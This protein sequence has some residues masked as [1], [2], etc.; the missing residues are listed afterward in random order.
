MN[1]IVADAITRHMFP[2]NVTPPK[3]LESWLVSMVDKVVAAYEFIL[4][5]H[6]LCFLKLENI[7]AVLMLV[8]VRF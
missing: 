8:L 1:P 2:L 6:K 3:Y 4:S 7:A 5:Y